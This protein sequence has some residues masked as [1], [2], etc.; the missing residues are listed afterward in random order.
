MQEHV[1]LV[2]GATSGVG[3]AIAR[4]VAEAGGRL[5][6]VSRSIARSRK[7]AEQIRKE[8][9]NTNI[10]PRKLDLGDMREIRKFSKIC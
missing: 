8:T 6:V 7:T 9:G 5:V 3:N 10:H 4:G 2:T 1:F